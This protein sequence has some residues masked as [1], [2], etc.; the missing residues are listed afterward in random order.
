MTLGDRVNLNQYIEA[1]NTEMYA[2]RPV[3]SIINKKSNTTIA[4]VG[5]YHAWRKYVFHA[6]DYAA[7]DV[8]CLKS[9]ISFI[10]GLPSLVE[11]K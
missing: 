1:I 2:N 10:E 11:K 5:Y 6:S 9:I 7:F 3:Y 4:Q 8:D